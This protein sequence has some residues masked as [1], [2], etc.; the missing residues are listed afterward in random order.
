MKTT[1]RRKRRGW[2][3][4]VAMHGSFLWEEGASIYLFKLNNRNTRTR[5]EISSKL[6]MKTSERRAMWRRSGVFIVNFTTTMST[7]HI[8][9]TF[10]LVFILLTINRCLLVVSTHFFNLRSLP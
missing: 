2:V 1:S 7:L 6:T 9:H 3:T 4:E 8:F 10:C 5:C